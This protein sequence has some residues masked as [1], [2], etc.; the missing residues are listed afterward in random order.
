MSE[1]PDLRDLVG[2]DVPGEELERLRRVHELLL[3]VGPPPELSPVLDSI[4]PPRRRTLERRRW[5]VLAF[6]G[7]MVVA[8]FVAGTIFGQERADFDATFTAHMSGIGTARSAAGSLEVGKRDANDNWPM[9]FKV[10]GLERNRPRGYYELLVIQRGRKLPCG[11]FIVREGTTTVHLNAPYEL[12]N[13]TKWVVALHRNGH[14][15]NP[16]V[17]MTTT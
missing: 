13:T 16:P 6:A 14:S 3:S 9:L 12:S 7:A 8:A 1:R 4:A 17:V 10:R 15:E 5:G 2:D 11:T